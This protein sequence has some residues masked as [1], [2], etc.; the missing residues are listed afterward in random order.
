MFPHLEPNAITIIDRVSP[1]ISPLKRGEIVVYYDNGIRIKRIIG[2]PEELIQISDGVVSL[3]INNTHYPLEESYLEEHMRTCV[4]GAC[5]NLGAHLYEIPGGHYFV[6]G[7]NRIN[8]R[9]S[10]GCTDVSDCVNVKP[11]YIPRQEIIGR[12]IFSW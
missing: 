10:R 4:P 2:L 5:T 9:D 11:H 3:L 12:V 7:D 8:S 1:K 6:L